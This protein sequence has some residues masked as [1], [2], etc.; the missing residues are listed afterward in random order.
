MPTWMRW[1]ATWIPPRQETRRWTV[2]VAWGRGAGPARRT[3]CSRVALAGRDGAGQGAPQHAVLGEHVHQLAVEADAGSLP[4]QRGADQDQPVQQ[5]DAADAV[6]QTVH[7]H[8]LTGSQRAGRGSC[9]R[10]PCAAPVAAEQPG[11]VHLGQPGRSA[12]A[13]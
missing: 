3:P 11:Q 9:G 5:G 2:T 6:D 1:R 8:A 7:F 13:G 12:W 4:G 10:R